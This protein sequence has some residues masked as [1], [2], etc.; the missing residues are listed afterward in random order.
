MQRRPPT[1]PT[2]NSR[3]HNQDWQQSRQLCRYPHISTYSV[4]VA[5]AVRR[6]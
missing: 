2:R 5:R 3:R 4:R 6:Q 1:G